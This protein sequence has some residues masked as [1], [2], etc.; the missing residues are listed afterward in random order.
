M[1]MMLCCIWQVRLLS[2][3]AALA[4]IDSFSHFSGILINWAKSVLFTLHP[5]VPSVDTHTQLHW[6]DEF[7][8]LGIQVGVNRAV[9][10]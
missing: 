3:C 1:L 8:Y 6:V 2:L 5:S 7:T 9:Y 10:F 4:V